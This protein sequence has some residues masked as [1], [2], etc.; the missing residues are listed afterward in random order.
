M[1]F[2]EGNEGPV[3]NNRLVGVEATS[4]QALALTG[5]NIGAVSLDPLLGTVLL[6]V[7]HPSHR[8][9]RSLTLVQAPLRQD[10]NPHP[11]SQIWLLHTMPGCMAPVLVRC[12]PY[13]QSK[14][15][16]RFHEGTMYAQGA[17]LI[18]LPGAI[19]HPC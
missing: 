4:S 8:V 14:I 12:G 9:R 6:H 2:S 13:A 5:P 19:D 10:L 15:V 16:Q 11:N 7:T 17:Y 3:A 1:P 18:A